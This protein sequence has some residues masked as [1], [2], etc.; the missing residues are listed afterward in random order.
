MPFKLRKAPKRDLY[1]VVNIET[2]HKYSKNP[3]PIEKAHAQMRV[4]Q[5]AMENEVHG[6]ILKRRSVS[7]PKKE[8]IK[9][10]THLLNLLQHPTRSALKAEYKSQRK[11]LKKVV[12]GGMIN[13]HRRPTET[14]RMN[15]EFRGISSLAELQRQ[16]ARELRATQQQTMDRELLN[17]LEKRLIQARSDLEAARERLAIL[18]SQGT[19]GVAV[20]EYRL[21]ITEERV[22]SLEKDIRE[23][24]AK[25]E[26]PRLVEPRRPVVTTAPLALTIDRSR[27][28]TAVPKLIIPQTVVDPRRRVV[29]DEPRRRLTEAEFRREMKRQQDILRDEL[30]KIKDNKK[31]ERFVNDEY[32]FAFRPDK[33]T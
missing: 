32:I 22:K 18:R 4:L 10:H 28:Y 14:E 6:G 27:E 16:E 17:L 1:W 19:T 21:K 7:I 30:S 24:Q 25:L 13:R 23:E 5:F 12:H 3:I 31:R 26:L 15:M 33:K 8:F 2:K 9:E 29:K 20:A 11:E